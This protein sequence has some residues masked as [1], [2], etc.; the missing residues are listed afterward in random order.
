MFAVLKGKKIYVVAAVTVI[1]ALASVLT[2]ELATAD[3]LQLI[4]TAVLGATVRNGIK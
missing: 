1:G 4:V 2:G 3:A